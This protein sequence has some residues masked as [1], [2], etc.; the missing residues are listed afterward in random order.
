MK[1]RLGVRDGDEVEM[2]SYARPSANG[3]DLC[4]Y[5]VGEVSLPCH[6]GQNRSRNH[7]SCWNEKSHPAGKVNNQRRRELWTVDLG[8][9]PLTANRG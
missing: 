8:A 4:P 1:E 5:W 7:S 3:I 2:D 6:F 9:N